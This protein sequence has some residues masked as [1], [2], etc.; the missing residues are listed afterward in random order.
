M[1]PVP[2]CCEIFKAIETPVWHDFTWT[3]NDLHHEGV[4]C[5]DCQMKRD[6]EEQGFGPL[7]E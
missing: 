5:D 4:I 7:E 1:E 3:E 2:N 6:F